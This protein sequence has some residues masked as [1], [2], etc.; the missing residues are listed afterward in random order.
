VLYSKSLG[1][2]LVLRRRDFRG[3]GVLSNGVYGGGGLAVLHL[4]LGIGV[5]LYLDGG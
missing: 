1:L 2:G 4:P 3:R 5:L